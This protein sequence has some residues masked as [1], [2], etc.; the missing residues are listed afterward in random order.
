MP[1]AVMN[2]IPNSMSGET[3]RDSEPNIAVNPS[4]PLQIAVSAFTLDP[5]SSGNAPIFVSTDGGNTW[6]LN[7]VLPGGNKT[8]D[9]TL[10]FG[11]TSNVLYAGILRVDN[12]RMNILRKANFAAPGLMTVLVNR[13]NED[14]PYVEAATVMGGS[15]VGSDR[16][17]VGHNDFNAP[18]G[19]TASIEE[20]ASAA[21][22]PP[23]AGFTTAR[24]DVRATAGQDGPPIR[25]TIH[26]S[27][28][29]YAIFD[30][31]R[32]A[33][34]T[35][36]VVVRDDSWGFSAT[37]FSSLLD[38]GD[39]LAGNLVVAGVSRPPFGSTLGT[40]RIGSGLSIAVDPRDWR[41]VYIAWADGTTANNLTLH[42][43]RSTDG[44][45]TWSGDLRTVTPATNPCLAVNIR[46]T[47]GFLYQQLGNPGT[48]NRWRTHLEI[49]TDGFAT[50][51]TD[52]LL[53]DVPDNNGSYTASNPIGDYA[54]LI[55]LGK[56]FYG[57]FSGNNTPIGANFPN[58]VT[59]ARNANWTTNTLLAVDNV[60]SVP[61]SIDP[62]FVR[63]PE[64][65]PEDDFYVRDWTDSPTS[66]DMGLEPSTHPVF[67]QTS[68]VWNRRGTL[69][70]P[71]PNDQP[72]N[73]DAGN[74]AGNIGDNWAFARIRRNTP[75]ASGSK[76]VT[77]HFLVSKLGT[78]SNY[79]DA[80][81]VDPDVSFPDP[82]PTVT[83][84]AADVGPI[85]TPAYHWHLN[86]V[87]S[88]HLC[89][90]VEISAPGDP[91][92][93]PSLVG[94]TPGWPTTDLR[95]IYDN[96]KAQ[97]NMGLSTTPASGVGASDSFY[98]IV[99]NAATFRRDIA[100]RYVAE[101]RVAE[102]L[103]DARIE[104][105]GGDSRP[106]KPGDT[107][108]FEKMEP[109]ENRWIGLSFRPPQGQDGEI[110]YVDFYEIV[111]NIAVNGFAIAAELAPIKQ[112]ILTCLERHRSVFTR[113]A[114]GFEI[115]EAEKE[116]AIAGELLASGA[117]SEDEYLEFLKDRLPVFTEI[118][119][120]L[121]RSQDADDPFG[122]LKAL[123]ILQEHI[124]AVQVEDA[125]VAHTAM[126]NKLDSFL[127]MRQLA[128]GDTADILQNVRWQKDLY[129]RVPA[130]AQLKCG[131][132]LLK[133]S[134]KF[135]DV[136]SKRRASN[137]DYPE[138]IRD[139]LDCFTE[140]A[141]I[142][143]D[144]ALKKAIVNMERHLGD[145][146]ALQRVHREYL[147]ALQK[148]EE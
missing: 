14:Q 23:P 28:R 29:I 63:Y 18:S 88:T 111:E 65:E 81:S 129:S 109:G 146:T 104:V 39:G 55:A 105:I 48:G 13:A 12:G 21:S 140:T 36:I 78:G 54:N 148:W 125:A 66:G 11:S 83:F 24:L 134:E 25:P 43:R 2:L 79:A 97:R 136:Y 106:F 47:V 31:W 77:A 132:S 122:V 71:F 93:A 6:T 114:A 144:E 42:L 60:T 107:V 101:P 82:D 3:G 20:S 99:H 138:L 45:A 10:R 143:G 131:P 130:L 113:V 80:G 74:G 98:A 32:S 147:L 35:D 96:N 133:Q 64:V 27:G 58:G 17:F 102:R 75:A 33:T 118:V 30:G 120:H 72:S 121:V 103:Q 19:Q 49:S 141:Q 9:T 91:F 89:L 86:P 40:Q 73:E 22:A 59:Y 115:E 38:P 69:P 126:L 117:V 124:E 128:Q 70:G 119:S 53:A 112:V 92:V 8:G 46:G 56:T 100:I 57:V 108:H 110:L 116:A 37:P 145:L 7:V 87:T 90:A 51:P 62:F 68:D 61:A 76:T 41:T 135:I 139:L 142:L 15:G 137:Q 127:T 85:I 16:V 4:N 5:L 52:F 26:P 84:N 44:G 123:S 94:N 95:V 1:L 34:T 50:G 67:Y